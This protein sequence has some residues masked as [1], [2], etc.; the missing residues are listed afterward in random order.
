MVLEWPTYRADPAAKVN[1]RVPHDVGK[2][3]VQQH[4]DAHG[5]SRF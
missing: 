4:R 1:E 2:Q 5:A 3:S